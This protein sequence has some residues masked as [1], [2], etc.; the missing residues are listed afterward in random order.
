MPPSQRALVRALAAND[1][2][3]D[4]KNGSCRL[5]FKYG[6]TTRSR[7]ACRQLA[8]MTDQAGRTLSRSGDGNSSESLSPTPYAYANNNPLQNTDPSGL[9][10]DCNFF[11]NLVLSGPSDWLADNLQHGPVSHVVSFFEAV[12][13]NVSFG[14]TGVIRE[15]I[16]PGSTCF[17][18]TDSFAYQAGDWATTAVSTAVPGAGAIKAGY[19]AY[20]GARA[21]KAATAV[22]K[23][24]A[25]R[26]TARG[27][28]ARAC[29]FAAETRIL[30]SDGST[31]A[32]EDIVPG[33]VVATT[34]PENDE[35][36]NREVTHTW[37]HQDDLY[38]LVIDGESLITT[39]DHPFWNITDQEWQRADELDI[40]ER[41]LSPSGKGGII[42]HF[43]QV[44]L[45]RASAYNLTI[46]DIHTYYVLAGDT[47]VLVHNEC[48]TFPRDFPTKKTNNWSATPWI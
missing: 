40:G 36:G 27:L 33:D 12:G 13:D 7:D 31:K 16:S 38:K 11:E 22:G 47:P 10:A 14:L 8:G 15:A 17:V 39:E 43:G 32:I 1:Q 41:L 6:R 19:A 24:V 44:P 28:A 25:E 26:R 48:E 5:V 2:L 29:S 46:E 30:M 4:P 45:K 18:K 42:D 9:C 20:K 34:D 21:I 37:V 23:E 3:W 35:D